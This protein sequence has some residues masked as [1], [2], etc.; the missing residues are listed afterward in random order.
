MIVISQEEQTR[1]WR[2]GRQ[3]IFLLFPWMPDRRRKSYI[4]LKGYRHLKPVSTFELPSVWLCVRGPVL[5]LTPRGEVYRSWQHGGRGGALRCMLDPCSWPA[6]SPITDEVQDEFLY[7]VAHSFS[8]S[9]RKEISVTTAL[10]L[11]PATLSDSSGGA[12]GFP[13]AAASRYSTVSE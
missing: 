7:L 11:C 3:G 6:V 9:G 8:N 4:I 12:L 13:S 5:A 10:P 2:A 1:K